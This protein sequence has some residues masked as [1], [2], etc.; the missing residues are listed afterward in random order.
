MLTRGN[1]GRVQVPER[2]WPLSPGRG[3]KHRR[4]EPSDALQQSSFFLSGIRFIVPFWSLL[5]RITRTR[6]GGVV[7]VPTQ[8]LTLHTHRAQY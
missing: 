2:S 7:L 1:P 8:F 4:F 6:N 3:A 5:E